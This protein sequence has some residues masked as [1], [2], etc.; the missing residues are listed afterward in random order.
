MNLNERITLKLD[1]G[2]DADVFERCAVALMA[3]HCENVVGIEGG[4]DGGRDG[5]I[6]APIADEPDSRG[7]TLVTTG[8][9]LSNLK[10]SRRT[11]KKFWDAGETFRVDQLVMITSRSLSDT[12]RRNIETYVK[13]MA[14]PC[15]AFMQ[16]SG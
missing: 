8:D 6:I 5:D 14:S 4:T 12:K 15:R 1:A 9:S 13:P 2:I 11:W 16:G 3:N 7:R 10:S